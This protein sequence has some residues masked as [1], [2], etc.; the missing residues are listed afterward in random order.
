[1]L[2]LTFGLKMVRMAWLDRYSHALAG[3]ALAACG[4]MIL[5]GF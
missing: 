5:V 3:A 4:G 1:V 2:S